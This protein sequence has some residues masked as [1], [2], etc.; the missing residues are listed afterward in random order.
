M[1]ISRI[2]IEGYRCFHDSTIEFNP[3]LNVLIGENNSGKTTVLQALALVF[4]GRESGRLTTEDFHRASACPDCDPRIQ[5]TVTLSATAGE[6]MEHKAI[7]A[8]WLTKIEAPWEATLTYAF[9][10]PEKDAEAFNADMR[11]LPSS[12]TNAEGR[13][14]DYWRLVDKYLPRFVSRV[15]GGNP[16]SGIRA[17]GE[18]LD[19]INFQFLDAIR[20]V[21]ARLFMGRNPMLREILSSVLDRKVSDN[22]KREAGR[23]QFAEI[24]QQLVENIRQRIDL[25]DVLRLSKETGAD[26]GGVPDLEGRLDESDLLAALRLMIR[27]N[28]T[29]VSLPATLNG[30]GYNN[31]IYISL[32]LA[33][34]DFAH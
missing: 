30:L 19:K 34:C 22:A 8:S 31:L 16:A 21:Q 29:G 24:S 7:V 15:W 1:Y 27:D 20:D 3:G 13:K 33:H 5:V 32:V 12:Q 14:A 17:E 4:G 9:F 18:W 23:K 25:E 6:P 11:E 2:R 28:S 26:V 10:L